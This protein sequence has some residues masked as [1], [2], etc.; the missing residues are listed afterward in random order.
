MSFGKSDGTGRVPER[1]V[2]GR[3]MRQQVVTVQFKNKH[4]LYSRS[5]TQARISPVKTTFSKRYTCS[6]FVFLLG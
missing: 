5:H 2:A 6:S 4:C 3:Q 1:R